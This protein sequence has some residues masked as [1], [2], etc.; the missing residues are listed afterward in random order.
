MQ[1]RHR[2]RG[3]EVLHDRRDHEG[4]RNGVPGDIGGE[5]VG[6]GVT[7]LHEHEVGPFEFGARKYQVRLIRLVLIQIFKMFYLIKTRNRN[8]NYRSRNGSL[9]T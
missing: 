9:S 2:A 7:D 3:G 6:G 8:Q 4:T 1:E 5:P